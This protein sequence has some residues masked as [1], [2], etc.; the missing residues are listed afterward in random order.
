[1]ALAAESAPSTRPRR[2]SNHRVATIAASTIEVTPVPV[3]T[4]TPQSSIRCHSVRIT[5][6]S[7][8]EIASNA[9]AARTTRR[10]PQRSITDAA[11]GPMRPKSA[12][13]IAT[14]SE[15]TARLQPN[16]ASSGTISTPGVA[17]T[18]A[19]TSRTT[20]VAPATIQA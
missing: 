5:V 20:K 14:A 18:P 9:T 3:P 13:L 11:N 19:V 12:M 7:A 4:S 6:V 17:R 15:M 2:W 8:T 10:S 1:M 16:S